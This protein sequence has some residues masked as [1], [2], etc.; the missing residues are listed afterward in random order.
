MS[1]LKRPSGNADKQRD[2]SNSRPPK[3][4]V[5]ISAKKVKAPLHK[6]FVNSFI[7]QD[8]K[9]AVINEAVNFGVPFLKDTA[10]NILEKILYGDDYS[11]SHS[12]RSRSGG[13]NKDYST[14]STW[15]N[16]N[17]R[18]APRS[19][20]TA[21]SVYDYGDVE[22]NSRLD[23]EQALTLLRDTID[24]YDR[25]AVGYLYELCQLSTIS[26]DYDFGWTDLSKAYTYHD[27]D[28]SWKIN[29]PRA[30]QL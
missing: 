17:R 22:F 27:G 20:M 2:Y 6:R 1:E 8:L 3:P 11:G 13:M 10:I 26:N 21:A 18:Q 15:R 9:T 4:E 28:G 23:A 5:T 7:K 30:V 25:V 12:Y 24:Q 14:I 29:L 16:S 19:N